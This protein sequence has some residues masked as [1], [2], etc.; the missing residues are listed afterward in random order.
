[1]DPRSVELDLPVGGGI[2]PAYKRPLA[3]AF[4]SYELFL[5][6]F[7][8]F[9][10]GIDDFVAGEIVGNNVL[11]TYNDKGKPKSAMICWHVMDPYDILESKDRPEQ[12][13][14]GRWVYI[15]F[16][17]THPDYRSVTNIKDSIDQVARNYPT[18][19]RIAFHRQGKQRKTKHRVFKRYQRDPKRLHIINLRRN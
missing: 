12:H 9:Y 14:D 8:L 2:S 10:D 11:A 18:A 15:P 16:M 3:E 1:M 19:K 6:E 17:V 4:R 7:G 5:S 13:P